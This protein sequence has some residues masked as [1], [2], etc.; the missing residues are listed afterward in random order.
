M[1]RPFP[2][3]TTAK[4]KR[5]N[6]VRRISWV[7]RSCC[8]R[9]GQVPECLSTV[10]VSPLLRNPWFS[11]SNR[12]TLVSII[13]VSAKQ[14]LEARIVAQDVPQR[15]LLQPC[16]RQD[17]GAGAPC[18]EA[19]RSWRSCWE[20]GFLKCPCAWCG[21]AGDAI[22]QHASLVHATAHGRLPGKGTRWARGRTRVFRGSA[23]E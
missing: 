4:G 1:G 15:I 21:L 22:V 2:T 9:A 14:L 5:E 16:H 17:R 13:V 11:C 12:S 20:A 7:S 18:D 8:R 3:R 6:R 23:E 19:L 10:P